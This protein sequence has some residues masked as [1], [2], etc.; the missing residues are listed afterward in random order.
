[1]PSS[2]RC[3][4]RIGRDT[5][6]SVSSFGPPGHH[7][8]EWQAPFLVGDRLVDLAGRS[9]GTMFTATSVLIT[10]T[11]FDVVIRSG[12]QFT[13]T[14]RATGRRLL[15]VFLVVPLAV[16]G[17]TG[18]GRSSRTARSQEVATSAAP[19]VLFL[20]L[21]LLL[22]TS[23][24]SSSV[25]PP[26]VTQPPSTAVIALWCGTVLLVNY[27]SLILGVTA[28][29]GRRDHFFA[30]GVCARERGKLPYINV[31]IAPPVGRCTVSCH[32]VT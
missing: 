13:A 15:A 26:S 31:P 23:T 10:A 14:V 30:R 29:T 12:E 18:D 17:S 21:G 3:P 7:R 1:M 24:R 4:P 28:Q 20:L 19:P 6:E 32:R 5:D 16:R 9:L 22:F 8:R 11:L 25:L 2:A 27:D